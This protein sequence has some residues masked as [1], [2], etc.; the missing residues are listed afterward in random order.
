LFGEKNVEL[1]YF[2]AITEINNILWPRQSVDVARKKM[3]P[4]KIMMIMKMIR[5]MINIPTVIHNCR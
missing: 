3:I 4:I 1:L 2:V 5:V